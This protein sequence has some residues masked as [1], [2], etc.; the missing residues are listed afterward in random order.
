MTRTV[1]VLFS[2]RRTYSHCLVTCLAVWSQSSIQQEGTWE[3]DVVPET[4]QL[5]EVCLRVETVT[6]VPLQKQKVIVI[7]FFFVFM[8]IVQTSFKH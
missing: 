1:D 3:R 4:P 8:T 7:M 6:S 2:A 5:E